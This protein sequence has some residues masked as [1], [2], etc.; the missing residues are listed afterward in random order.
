V[1]NLLPS[2]LLS[3]NIKIKTYRIIILPVVLYG[4]ENW[5]LTMRDERRMCVIENGALKRIFGSKRNEVTGEWTKLHKE[6]L[7]KL[8]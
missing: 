2:D 3:K 5:S 8:Y 7:N 4:S 1:Q 6:E